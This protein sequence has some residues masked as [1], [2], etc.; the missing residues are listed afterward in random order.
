MRFF[1]LDD[2][3]TLLGS[4]EAGS[5][6]EVEERASDTW[7]RCLDDIFAVRRLPEEYY[8]EQRYQE[9]YCSGYPGL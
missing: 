6:Q 7:N 9:D 3:Y 8:H 4:I 1:I 5:K 2:E